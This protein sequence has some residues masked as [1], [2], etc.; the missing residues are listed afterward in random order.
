[1]GF[2]EILEL[3]LPILGGIA[4]V[5]GVMWK[6]GVKPLIEWVRKTL[7]THDEMVKTVKFIKSEVSTNGG[8]SIKDR[9]NA[10][11][12]TCRAMKHKQDI[13]E[14]RSHASLHYFDSALFE[15]NSD[16]H[17]VWANETF[18]ELTALIGDSGASMSGF[19]WVAFVHE[20]ERTS[21]LEEFSSCI[22]M[23][24]KFERVTKTIK[25]RMIKMT[26]FPYKI[27]DD[28]FEG[29]LIHISEI[30]IESGE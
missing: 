1:M 11:Y 21:F 9:V 3:V 17:L 20:D 18:Y 2:Y 6:K 16:G 29:F 27:G 7:E 28:E 4:A 12:E 5:I 10:L 15:T 22:N 26:G 30:E 8:N 14:E 13:A 25:N 24:R 19:D 23:N